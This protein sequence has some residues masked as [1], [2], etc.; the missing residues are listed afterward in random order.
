MRCTSNDIE[1]YAWWGIVPASPIGWNAEY[2]VAAPGLA[3]PGVTT[4]WNLTRLWR[5]AEALDANSADRAR[6]SPGLSRELSSMATFSL[7]V[8]WS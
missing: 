7:K 4:N 5:M 2:I 3:K 1:K 8:I 6:L